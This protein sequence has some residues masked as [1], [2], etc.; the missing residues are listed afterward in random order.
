[1]DRFM[2][3]AEIYVIIHGGPGVSTTLLSHEL[4]QTATVQFEF[5]E[6]DA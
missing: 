2:I 5:G 4:I 3:H 6:A 1:M